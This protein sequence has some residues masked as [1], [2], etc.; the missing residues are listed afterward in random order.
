MTEE[1]QN[2]ESA[3][4]LVTA[5]IDQP[6]GA[7]SGFESRYQINI[8]YDRRLGLGAPIDLGAGI[9]FLAQIDPRSQ[10]TIGNYALAA[11][12]A[13]VIG[14]PFSIPFRDKSDTIHQVDAG[15]MIAIADQAMA[16]VLAL[17]EAKWAL[18]DRVLDPT[19]GEIADDANWP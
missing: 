7:P 1:T 11:T 14:A 5:V 10:D 3:T 16:R 19:P 17:A 2:Q 13:Q 8:E 6:Y 4:P 9:T 12:R 18:K 15:Q